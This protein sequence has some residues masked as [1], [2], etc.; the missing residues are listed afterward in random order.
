MYADSERQRHHGTYFYSHEPGMDSMPKEAMQ[1][2]MRDIL[3]NVRQN[4]PP[5]AGDDPKILVPKRGKK[6][7][8][9]AQEGEVWGHASI[10]F[11]TMLEVID[12][13]L[14][15]CLTSVHQH[16]TDVC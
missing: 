15:N 6:K 11:S 7:C 16:M 9:W 12:F 10:N 14:D 13:D 2:A 1:V 3:R 4:L 8:S 5:G